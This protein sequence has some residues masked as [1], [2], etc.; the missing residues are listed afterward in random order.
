LRLSQI[1]GWQT[2]V[3]I[4]AGDPIEA[5]A[6]GEEGLAL[7]DAT[8]DR[9][10]SR[11]CRSWGIATTRSMAGDLTGAIEQ[12]REIMAEADA[13]GDAI[14]AFLGRIGLGHGLAAVG[15]TT[16]AHA[17]AE[18]AVEIAP[19]LSPFLEAYAYAPLAVAAL[20]AGD[21]AAAEKASDTAW[22]RMG[23]Q[24]EHATA[25]VNPLAEI[26]LARGDL[27]AAR[28][29]ADDSVSM[30][31]G[32][33]LARALAT[34][35]R[36]A[37]AQGELERAERDV[38]Q[39][40]T[41]AGDFDA[42][43]VTPDALESSADL[44]AKVGNHRESARLFAAADAL[45]QRMGSVRFKIWQRDYDASLA[46][47]RNAMGEED[48]ESAWAEGA[49]LSTEEAIAYAQRGRG[50]RK[51]PSSGWASLTP[52]ELD[53]V[54]LVSEGRGNKDIAARLFVSHR[55]VQTHL[56]HVYTKLGLTSRV[57]LAQEAAKHA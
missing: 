28:R 14:H 16:A 20:A 13:D 48:F 8:G 10:M 39:A 36:V 55:T 47:L 19:D 27:T 2:Y 40:L 12:Y 5:R 1:L 37:I 17:N 46:G 50:E 9:F 35:A 43:Q 6:A 38:Q 33:H 45:R 15:E 26:A 31:T 44:A 49:A 29:W 7:A 34:R 21:L 23:I 18:A 22:Q 56:T 54:R 53:V 4:L 11:F 24:L 32:W 3:A 51:R 42:H 30:M 25:N 52:T 41:F 57:A